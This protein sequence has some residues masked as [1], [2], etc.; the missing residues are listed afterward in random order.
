MEII[1]LEEEM[2]DQDEQNLKLNVKN[3]KQSNHSVANPPREH[4]GHQQRNDSY[5]LKINPEETEHM[6]L[7]R[8]IIKF[9]DLAGI[10]FGTKF[11]F[12]WKPRT[13][14]MY[15]FTHFFISFI[16]I[17]RQQYMHCQ[18]GDHFRIIELFA[19]YGI[20]ISVL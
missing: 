10:I 17:L 4:E 2:E 11:S 8:K 13:Y 7:F 6:K 19:I 1:D 14:V 18:N 16:S 5:L 20:G 3:L 15:W 9:F 12:D